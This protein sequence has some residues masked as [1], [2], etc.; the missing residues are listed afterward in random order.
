M[1]HSNYSVSENGEAEGLISRV[2]TFRIEVSLS[3]S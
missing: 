3:G 1:L 2:S